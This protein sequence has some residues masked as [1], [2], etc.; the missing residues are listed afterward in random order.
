MWRF[1]Y[2]SASEWTILGTA[3][4]AAAR[5]LP[6]RWPKLWGTTGAAGA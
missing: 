6:W 5:H 1:T 4:V 2:L 3:E